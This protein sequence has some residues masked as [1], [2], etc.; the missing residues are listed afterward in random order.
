MLFWQENN[1]SADFNDFFQ[2]ISAIISQNLAS[3]L[4]HKQFIFD[5]L[6]FYLERKNRFSIA[7]LLNLVCLLAKDLRDEFYST[8]GLNIFSVL[9]DI[10]KSSQLNVVDIQ[11]TFISICY[12]FKYLNSSILSDMFAFMNIF[13]KLLLVECEKCA[14]NRRFCAESLGYLLRKCS[15]DSASLNTTLS[16][17]FKSCE[18]E[19]LNAENVS[20]V[21]LILFS[22][23]KSISGKLNHRHVELVLFL[24]NTLAEHP[25]KNEFVIGYFEMLYAHV[26]K[27]KENS[28]NF[29]Q[30]FCSSF[31]QSLI[32]SRVLKDLEDALKL[33]TKII[34]I[35]HGSLFHV[36]LSDL[37][38][39]FNAINDPELD[40]SFHEKTVIFLA[41]V[42][43]TK[44]ADLKLGNI[45]KRLLE[46]LLCH[47]STSFCA[48]SLALVTDAFEVSSLSEVVKTVNLSTDSKELC[49]F[50]SIMAKLHPASVYQIFENKKCSNLTLNEKIFLALDDKKADLLVDCINS[51][52]AGNFFDV[53]VI[54][55]LSK[56]ASNEFFSSR[57][58]FEPYIA[59]LHVYLSSFSHK[60]YSIYLIFLKRIA[61]FHFSK[62]MPIFDEMINITEFSANLEFYRQK[63]V[64]L[65]TL[66][67]FFKLNDVPEAVC[68]IVSGFFVG[69]LFEKFELFYKELIKSIDA[70]SAKLNQHMFLV[71]RSKLDFILNDSKEA[72]DIANYDTNSKSTRVPL[73]FAEYQS[74]LALWYTENVLQ[75]S[76]NGTQDLIFAS[77]RIFNLIGQVPAICPFEQR[78]YVFNLLTAR[79]ETC[80]VIKRNLKSILTFVSK[81]KAID[82]LCLEKLLLSLLSKPDPSL[83]S[84]AL[85]SLFAFSKYSK[86]MDQGERDT[87]KTVVDEKLFKA[88]LLSLSMKEELTRKFSMTRSSSMP[89]LLR[90]LYGRLMTRG[91]NDHEVVS[92]KKSI[93]R[94][95]ALLE[96]S[97]LE[98]F[99]NYCF[100]AFKD[101]YTDCFVWNSTTAESAV[102]ASSLCFG[103]LNNVE[104]LVSNLGKTLAQLPSVIGLIFDCL[105]YVQRSF[106][107]NKRLRLLSTKRLHEI[108]KLYISY[109]GDMSFLNDHFGGVYKY[110]LLPKV[111]ENANFAAEFLQKKPSSLILMLE[112]WSSHPIFISYFNVE[113]VDAILQA[114][115]RD[116]GLVSHKSLSVVLACFR[117]ILSGEVGRSIF[118]DSPSAPRL[119]ADFVDLARMILE[120]SPNSKKK[121][122]MFYAVLDVVNN[123]CSFATC[124][125]PGLDRVFSTVLQGNPAKV[126]EKN[127]LLIFSYIRQSAA[128]TEASSVGDSF[129]RLQKSLI[130][131]LFTLNGTPV[132]RA[133]VETLEKF[134]EPAFYDI[135][136]SLNAFSN[137]KV[138]EIDY[139]RR[140]KAYAALKSNTDFTS[141]TSSAHSILAV[142]YT[143]MYFVGDASEFVFRDSA[144]DLIAKFLEGTRHCAHFLLCVN[145]ILDCVRVLYRS[146]QETVRAEAFA[147]LYAVVKN[148]P[149]THT[150]SFWNNSNYLLVHDEEANFYVNLFHMQVHRRIRAVNRLAEFLRATEFSNGAFSSFILPVLHSFVFESSE[151]ADKNLADASINAVSVALSKSFGNFVKIK[152]YFRLLDKAAYEAGAMKIIIAVSQSVPKPEDSQEGLMFEKVVKKDLLPALL[153][154]MT[155]KKK[156][157]LEIRA[158]VALAAV[159]VLKMCSIEFLNEN[160][161]R[162]F[163]TLAANLKNKEQSVRDDCRNVIAKIIAE[164]G[165]EYM[166][167]LFKEIQSVLNR[168]ENQLFTFFYTCWF[169]LSTTV[170]HITSNTVEFLS[171]AIFKYLLEHEDEDA[172][173]PDF[174]KIKESRN[175]KTIEVFFYL[176][177]KAHSLFQ[178]ET[179]L[180]A[181]EV[182]VSIPRKSAVFRQSLSK[183]VERISE[184]IA[185]NSFVEVSAKLGFCFKLLNEA[186]NDSFVFIGCRVLNVILKNSSKISSIEDIELLG[187]F[188]EKLINLVLTAKN[189]TII[190]LALGCLFLIGQ[191]IPK[192]HDTFID[193]VLQ[194]KNFLFYLF[195][196]IVE[197][198]SVNDESSH[199]NI[200]LRILSIILND[201]PEVT[202]KRLNLEFF[203]KEIQNIVILYAKVGFGKDASEIKAIFCLLRLLIQKESVFEEMYDIAEKSVFEI[204]ITSHSEN[205]K[206]AA[207]QVFLDYLLKYPLSHHR[208]NQIIIKIVSNL[209]YEYESGKIS[210]IN[211]LRTF[212]NKVSF[213][214]FEDSCDFIFLN[215]TLRFAN[216]RDFVDTCAQLG[217]CVRVLVE[218]ATPRKRQD[219]YFLASKWLSEA[220]ASNGAADSS[221]EKAAKAVVISTAAIQSI[222]FGIR[223]F[224]K[225]VADFDWALLFL[226]AETCFEK[227]PLA[228]LRAYLQ[229]LRNMH[230]FAEP[231]LSEKS[232]DFWKKHAFKDF[233]KT[234]TH[235]SDIISIQFD[236]LKESL[237]NYPSLWTHDGDSCKVL[238]NLMISYAFSCDAP[239]LINRFALVACLALQQSFSAAEFDLFGW[240]SHKLLCI[241]RLPHDKSHS[242]GNFFA[243]SIAFYEQIVKKKGA[244][245][246]KYAESPAFASNLLKFYK[247][248]IGLVFFV[249]QNGSSLKLRDDQNE[250]MQSLL[251]LLKKDLPKE[252]FLK[253][254][255]EQRQKTASVRHDR[256]VK[257]KTR[258]ITTSTQFDAKKRK[259]IQ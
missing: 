32:A 147:I 188:I 216:E 106:V 56:H 64:H 93:F 201:D 34:K 65:K 48:W 119:A 72:A 105:L 127:L 80:P 85:G 184:G 218:K 233:S 10:L 140:L 77:L 163:L 60:N 83:Q 11:E 151:K 59:G 2:E 4:F 258:V 125:L 41:S 79:F 219:M 224:T 144:V 128:C 74:W 89:L 148:V 138:E 221:E 97:E 27:S 49:L 68:L 24:Q 235:L 71:L 168:G 86:S 139:E 44:I 162:L 206:E 197:N 42:L 112:T 166:L 121:S 210:A 220:V 17:L 226:A 173:A 54:S 241:C 36:V 12:L 132:R 243:L 142:V 73:S 182:H 234:E 133:L 158:S 232:V 180:A 19:F 208:I 16:L 61:E 244:F 181:V 217:E 35:S 185:A 107:T 108:Y 170:L 110:V 231:L 58:I 67:M 111:I 179:L 45:I 135:V 122:S 37:C 114:V 47:R 100:A 205:L 246:D 253:L 251:A 7:S 40:P 195:T 145:Q 238:L 78:E 153:S 225:D 33:Y 196:Q 9:R 69:C 193:S 199:S 15:A 255:D 175:P 25:L 191:S 222:S 228:I 118:R 53:S 131:L 5:R 169:V 250:S 136:C 120:K 230:S 57:S 156:D 116:I 123:L 31:L 52:K 183:I 256:L 152:R 55:Y 215:L 249:E 102:I 167:Y 50:A 159:N 1:L 124:V 14:Y 150:L 51:F 101:A 22:A 211:L 126:G 82:D 247:S 154:H 91:K 212:L 21:S 137:F 84:L 161:P 245:F 239:Q 203:K 13:K 117:S 92:R 129:S 66:E 18:Q 29:Y 87:L 202:S 155:Q 204:A 3:V 99:M 146:K 46:C 187:V 237:Q 143:L 259:R 28:V 96:P 90:I 88:E 236:I 103:V 70:L 115:R 98:F 134:I 76:E 213:E 194:N 174:V 176:A 43:N 227:L 177:S 165:S 62:F 104:E 229:L 192:L 23:S 63:V 200:C 223:S 20:N 172:K 26:K 130:K 248:A 95:L 178:L 39:N 38:E 207:K 8:F 109:S 160:V 171:T 6:V 30:S 186:K 198:L 214:V 164:V 209:A 81:L 157:A 141:D 94:F 254:W 252:D 257:R 240:F 189:H 190:K 242:F 113:L 75:V 149:D